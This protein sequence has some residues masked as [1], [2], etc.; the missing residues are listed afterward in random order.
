M[1]LTVK[2]LLGSTACRSLQ[3]AQCAT[4]HMQS[5]GLCHD[6]ALHVAQGDC[7]YRQDQ[8]A[9]ICSSPKKNSCHD[10]L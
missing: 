7:L 6:H 3:L 1:L 2:V 5:L 4:I 9:R 10:G 8:A